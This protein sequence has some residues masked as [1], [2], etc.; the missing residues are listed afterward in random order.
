[1]EAYAAGRLGTRVIATQDA[2]RNVAIGAD[3]MMS[4]V[5][6]ARHGYSRRTSSPPFRN[7]VNQ[8][9]DVVHDET[10]SVPGACNGSAIRKRGL[11]RMDFLF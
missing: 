5:E 4:A 2:N 3:R 6:R 8:L 1:M 11:S 9:P 10:K 7:G